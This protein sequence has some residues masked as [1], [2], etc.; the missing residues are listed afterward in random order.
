MIV[1]IFPKLKSFKGINFNKNS[2]NNSVSYE[3]NDIFNFQELEKHYYLFNNLNKL[4]ITIITNTKTKNEF[5]FILN[6]FKFPFKN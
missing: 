4:S 1:E 6:S 3:L 5:L 2:K